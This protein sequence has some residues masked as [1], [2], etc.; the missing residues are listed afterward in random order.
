MRSL[1]RLTD[2]GKRYRRGD[3]VLTDIALTIDPGQALGVIGPNGAGKS[4]LLRIIAGLTRPT[5]GRR[6]GHPAIGYLPDRFP[7]GHRMH[8]HAYLTHLGRLSGL[9]TKESSERA[10]ALLERLELVGSVAAGGPL[11]ELSKGNAQKVG[12]AQALI[13]RPD[14]LVLDEPFSGLDPAAHGTLSE[15]IGETR[16][17]GAA[18]VFTDHRAD[19]A[20]EHATTLYRIDGGELSTSDGNVPEQT[21]F[22]VTL[23]GADGVIDEGTHGVISVARQ[24]DV[25]EL[26]VHAAHCDE[27]LLRALRSGASIREVVLG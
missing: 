23:T 20:A 2:V 5:A 26:V 13:H 11:R 15:L 9:S 19:V 12:L 22:R 8:A 7:A 16:D 14:V 25:V 21:R 4:T 18:V 17:R 1:L 27:I 3:P 6:E 24:G 10:E